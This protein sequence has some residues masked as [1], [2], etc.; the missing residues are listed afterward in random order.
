MQGG[1]REGT[2]RDQAF[3]SRDAEH[4]RKSD[5]EL[6]ESSSVPSFLQA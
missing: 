4:V 5:L 1:R 6:Y 3:Q 2:G